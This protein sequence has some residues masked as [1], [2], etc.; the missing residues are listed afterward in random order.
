MIRPATPDDIQNIS[1]IYAS[2]HSEE[3]AGRATTGWVRGIYP[4]PDTARDALARGELF[5]AEE[6]GAVV[7]A[8]ILNQRQVDVY[9][10]A[11]WRWQAPDSQVMVLHTLV[12]DPAA[13]GRGYGRAFVA[14][15][16]AW[17]RAHGCTCLR[18]D[19][20]A[21]NLPARAL[22]CR[23]GYTEAAIVPCTFNGLEG[24]QLVLLEK[25]L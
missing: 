2:I 15:Y 25:H 18:M 22:Y 24:V 17:A 16:E 21:R 13:K 7:G 1:N 20:N 11:P 19:T 5:V 10:G 8:A 3:E 23:L 9:A 6:G 12:I 14:Y 4:T